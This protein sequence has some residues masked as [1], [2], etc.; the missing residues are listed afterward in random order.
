M[1][2]SAQAYRPPTPRFVARPSA[3]SALRPSPR[4]HVEECRPQPRQS[5]SAAVFAVVAYDARSDNGVVTGRPRTCGA[6]R[7]EVRSSAL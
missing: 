6:G 4:Q 1:F 2:M 7:W 5:G 3:P